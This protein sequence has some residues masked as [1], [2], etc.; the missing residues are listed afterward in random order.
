MSGILHALNRGAD[1]YYVGCDPVGTPK[2]VADATGT[3]VK[4]REYGPW[5]RLLSDSNPGFLLPF[6]LAGGLFDPDT[7]LVRF[8]NRDL[9]VLSGHWTTHDPALY[10]GGQFNLTQY[11]AADPVNGRDPTGLWCIGFSAYVGIGGGIQVCCKNGICSA[12]GEVGIGFGLG[13]ALGSGGP[14]RDA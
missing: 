10:G 11:A 9:D 6:G 13:G 4:R 2:I 8:W 12:C 14:E 1:R 3:V 5:G 7:G